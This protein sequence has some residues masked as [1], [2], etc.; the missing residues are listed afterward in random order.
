[1]EADERSFAKYGLCMLDVP[2]FKLLN[3]NWLS[4]FAISF[5]FIDRRLQVFPIVYQP[6]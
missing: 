5:E 6:G 3:E 1:M 4:E 2:R